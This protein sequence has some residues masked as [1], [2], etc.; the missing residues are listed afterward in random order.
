MVEE[1]LIFP[2]KAATNPGSA[3]PKDCAS[4]VKGPVILDYTTQKKWPAPDRHGQLNTFDFT[5]PPFDLTFL[6]FLLDL[7]LP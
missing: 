3:R 6:P 4:K 2:E 1:I 5:L 7:V